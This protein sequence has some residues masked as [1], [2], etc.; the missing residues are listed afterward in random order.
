L[1]GRIFD[2]ARLVGPK[3]IV[4]TTSPITQPPSP[5][6][7]PSNFQLSPSDFINMMVTQLQN[8][9]PLDPTKNQDLLA[10]MSQIGQIQSTTQLQDLMKNMSLQSSLGAAGGLIG[11]MVTGLDEN[12]ANL[13]GQ[14]TSVGVAGTDVSLELDNGKTLKLASVTGISPAPTTPATA[15]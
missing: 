15:G 10:Q 2:H 6:Q 7:L 1:P 4:M 13:S 3:G 11:K 5:N 14:V 8:Q 9:D 12:G